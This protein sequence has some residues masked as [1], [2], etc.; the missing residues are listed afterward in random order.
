MVAMVVL[1]I[2]A[3]ALTGSWSVA[4]RAAH[5]S[6]Q[7]MNAQ[8]ALQSVYDSVADVAFEQLLSW[9]GVAVVRGDHVVTVSAT[10]IGAGLIQVAFVATEAATGRGA[11]RLA[12][13]RSGET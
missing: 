4:T 11:G 12:T 10:L 6:D 8:A 1:A 13:L 2:S 3:L 7:A 9:N 5:D